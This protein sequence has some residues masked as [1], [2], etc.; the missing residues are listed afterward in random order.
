MA[1]ESPAKLVA[2]AIADAAFALGIQDGTD[3][4]ANEIQGLIALPFDWFRQH[5]NWPSGVEALTLKY[6]T[7]KFMVAVAGA[8]SGSL[9]VLGG[10]VLCIIGIS[11]T[12]N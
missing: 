5:S 2:E 1:A 9:C 3:T 4:I 12:I 8:I 6:L 10:I 11:G 7:H